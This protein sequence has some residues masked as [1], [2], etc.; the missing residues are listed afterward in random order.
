MD[1]YVNV[2]MY[3]EGTGSSAQQGQN[4][5]G[6]RIRKEIKIQWQ[7]Q[8][9][10]VDAVVEVGLLKAAVAVNCSTT[11]RWEVWTSGAQTALVHLHDRGGPTS[12]KSCSGFQLT[13]WT[14]FQASLHYICQIHIVWWRAML[15]SSDPS[16][17]SY[18]AIK[19]QQK[20][21]W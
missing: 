17:W 11:F 7:T 3:E 13:A 1:S 6:W 19:L 4:K 9:L 16:P 2:I 5:E 15:C 10:Q 18:T 14:S 12:S 21:V 20:Y 8:S